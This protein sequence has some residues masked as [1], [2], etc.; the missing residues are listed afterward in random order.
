[1]DDLI[2]DLCSF[3]AAM[4]KT[5]ACLTVFGLAVFILVEFAQ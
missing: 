5:V 2:A 1:M 3:V 4:A